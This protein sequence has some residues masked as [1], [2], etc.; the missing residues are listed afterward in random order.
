MASFSDPLF[1]NQW[2]L[3]R[4]NVGL[5]WDDYSGNGVTVGVFDDGVD[6][7]H[8]DLDGN[9]DSSLNLVT[10]GTNWDAFPNVGENAH[11][12]AIAGIIAAEAGNNRGGVGVAYE[13]TLGAVDVFDD[14]YLNGLDEITAMEHM[15]T[16]DITSNSWGYE[17]LFFSFQNSGGGYGSL[18]D[19][20][21]AYQG[22]A[23]QGRDGLGTVIVQAAGNDTLN[24]QGTGE[25]TI[26]WAITVGATGTTDNVTDYSNFGTGL[27]ISAPAATVTTDISG[28]DGYSFSD[29][30]STFGGTSAATPVVSGVVALML[31]ANGDLGWRDVQTVLAMSAAQTGSTFGNAYT[32]YEQGDWFAN[33]AT[34]W[35]GGGASF[36]LSYGFGLI[37]ALA[38]VR[39]A[40][41][42]SYMTQEAAV[43]GNE[44]A[45]TV[46]S[47]PFDTIPTI[48]SVTSTLTVT[49][50]IQI[51]YVNVTLDIT[52]SYASN[53]SAFLVSPSGQEYLLF[54]G[55][56]FDYLM[57]YGWDWTFGIAA[58]QGE[59]SAGDWSVRIDD[60]T[61][62][63]GGRL[64]S[65]SVEFYGSEASADD[66]H[67]FTNDFM[68]LANAD[69]GRTTIEDTDGGTDWLNFAAVSGN[70]VLNL[71]TG[72]SVQGVEWASFSANQF[73]N[74]TSGDGND[75][76]IGNAQDNELHGNRGNDVLTG[77]G[78]N[79]TIYGG[80]G[81]DRIDTGS[82]DD[83]IYGGADSADL[84]D[85]ISSGG[86][87]DY[88]DS[89]YGNDEVYAGAG[90]DTI[91]G[92]FGT[93]RLIGQTGDDVIAGGP[94]S[95]LIFGGDGADFVNG[96]FGHDRINGG[97]GA[98]SFY[99]LGI[100]DHGSDWIQDY[101]SADGDVLVFAN[102]DASVDDFQ[103]NVA[104]TANAGISGVSESFVI[105]K[106]TGQI[107]WA[108]VDG[109]AQD[110]INLQIGG[111][112]FDIA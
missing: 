94:L 41:A 91:I 108:L 74:V 73:E 55:I 35:N 100:R 10:G 76:L 80:N 48:G 107:I 36:N 3:G 64:N 33:D 72:V 60:S 4:I 71:N 112:V 54:D 90:N 12:T 31:E 93:D 28:S 88:I 68:E 9:F 26:R 96:G 37:D 89:G 111:T 51:E 97:A 59:S 7:N 85:E 82:G 98:D 105:Y 52:H 39:M 62:G 103:V 66:I 5:V 21:D 50:D 92:G 45:V 14:I 87:N 63:N 65:V 69:S 53:L 13:A 25:H 109:N 75:R 49:E 61:Y 43:S 77:G 22:N 1:S 19:L 20:A 79:D 29:Y 30:T 102:S 15:R 58:L 17:P 11:G 8:L 67:H 86:G 95:D 81:F 34:N 46:S 83:F 70:V 40:E 78:G 32:G 24:V 47:S 18:R 110:E 56:G 23:E 6:Y 104:E 38:A 99:H 106:P 44:S 42:W 57:D 16:F 101:N 2:H 84:R 27:L